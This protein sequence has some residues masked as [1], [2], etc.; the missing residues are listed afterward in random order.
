MPFDPVFKELLKAFF[1]EFL[2]LFFP[3]AAAR[4]DFSEVTFLDKELFTHLPE[5]ALREPDLVAELRTKEGE[6][7]ILLIHIE[8]QAQRHRE[9]AYR[10]FEYYALLRLRTKKPVYPAALFLLPG[11]GGITR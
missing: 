7:E 2:E 10:M 11:T 4:L 3:E 8:V 9:F 5:G 6:P 1:R